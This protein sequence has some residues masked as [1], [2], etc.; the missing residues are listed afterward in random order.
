M[1]RIPKLSFKLRSKYVELILVMFIDVDDNFSFLDN[2]QFFI[3]MLSG[4]LSINLF[5]LNIIDDHRYM[6]LSVTILMVILLVREVK[7][8]PLQWKKTLISQS[9]KKW[10]QKTLD[11][12]KVKSFSLLKQ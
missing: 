11:H 3:C 6:T 1:S 4:R 5:Q 8:L 7:Q 9:S 2:P 12:C 10:L